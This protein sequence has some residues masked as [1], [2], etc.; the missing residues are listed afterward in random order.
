MIVSQNQQNNTECTIPSPQGSNG[1]GVQLQPQVR[2]R[3]GIDYVA[4]NVQN[5]S[6]GNMAKSSPKVEHLDYLKK[7]SFGKVPA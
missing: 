2:S 5:A 6:T 3:N 1:Q 7:E 4:R